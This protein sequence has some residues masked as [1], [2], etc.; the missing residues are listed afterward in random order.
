MA[1]QLSNELSTRIRPE[2]EHFVQVV[3]LAKN[4]L[5]VFDYLHLEMNKRIGHSTAVLGVSLFLAARVN[6]AKFEN[7]KGIRS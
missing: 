5:E 6:H 4:G 7:V 2:N 1:K 3:F